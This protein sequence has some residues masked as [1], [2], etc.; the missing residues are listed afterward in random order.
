MRIT[1]ATAAATVLAGAGLLLNPSPATAEAHIPMPMVYTLA[2]EGG[3]LCAGTVNAKVNVF[4]DSDQVSIGY[5]AN[6]DGSG[7]CATTVMFN[8]RNLDTGAAGTITRHVV[9][10]S[11][12]ELIEPGPGNIVVELVTTQPHLPPQSRVEFRA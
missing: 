4:D 3:G 6:F 2:T 5:Q 1:G 9:S 7:G 11:Y 10:W 12:A 8:W